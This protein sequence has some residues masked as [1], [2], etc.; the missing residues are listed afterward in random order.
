[1]SW[2]TLSP[3]SRI[4][5]GQLL[6]FTIGRR[7]LVVGRTARGFFALD[8]ACPHAGGSLSEGMLDA[9]SVVCPIHG[10]AYDVTTGEGLD[11][12]AEVRVHPC[13]LEGDVLRIEIQEEET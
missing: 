4:R 5:E 1:M 8:D 13:V 7:R 9:G 2:H 10:Y 6:C 12:G 3:A 11:D